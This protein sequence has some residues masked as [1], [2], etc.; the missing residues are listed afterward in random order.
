MLNR[1]QKLMIRDLE[2]TVIP[3]N[4]RQLSEKYGV[5]L[6]T[7]RNDINSIAECLKGKDADFI[8]IPGQ[9][10]RII[11]DGNIS[12]GLDQ[13]LRN[14][15]FP[16]LDGRQRSI[17]LLFN[18]LF[19]KGPLS[20]ADLCTLFDVSKGTVISAIKQSN[21]MNRDLRMRIVRHQNKG[22]CLEASLKNIVNGCGILMRQEGEELIYGTLICDE[23]DFITEDDMEKL[24][25]TLQYISNDLSLYITHH[26]F[27]SFM[28][29]CMVCHSSGST[30]SH[31][32]GET[33]KNDR[34]YQLASYLEDAFSIRLDRNGIGILRHLLSN[35]T[36]YSAHTSGGDHDSLLQEA[37][38]DMIGFVNGSGM[39]QI[40]DIETLRADLLIHLKSTMEAID[41]GLSRDNPLLDEIRS[42]YPNE[43]NLIKSAAQR[44]SGIYPVRLDDDEVG[45]LTLYFLR[46]FDKSEKIQETR[47][48]VV[49]NTGRS[50]SKLLATRLI[51]NIPDI[52]IVSMS[53]IYNIDNSPG[54]LDNVDFV[55]ST[56]P[57]TSISKPY[58]VISPLL[59]KNEIVK[60]KE[61]IWLA[62]SEI[63]LGGS[64]DSVTE[65][66]LEE[67]SKT[68]GNPALNSE[69]YDA[70]NIIPFNAVTLLGEVSMN[71]FYL[72]SDLYPK[73]IPVSAFGNVS[74]IYAHVLMSVPRWQ[75]NEF[76]EPHDDEP[77][78][79][80][81]RKQ[82][83]AIRKYLQ[84][85][86]E[87]L[88]IM[89]PDSEIIAI[90]RYYVY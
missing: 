57:I 24:D 12:A 88:G 34:L 15:E 67:H 78:I 53:S 32:H 80:Q 46:S 16:Y 10:M 60:V 43:F 56:I 55:I 37:V 72:I 77:L 83:E 41:S 39:Y 11:S 70:R 7:V 84:Q 59:Q 71:L 79:R 30:R 52:H 86:S 19:A 50:A 13:V 47:V 75:R 63:Q 22:Y 62:N 87:R 65:S 48:M 44:F 4:A 82:Y 14:R 33:D 36:D 66:I 35:S 42:S 64:V 51:N 23:N 6:R 8:R 31:V 26:L 76:I 28:L 49:C 61:A 9:G 69:Y 54:I 27:L 38:D 85:E 29:Y 5:S 45:Y 2:K 3:V 25:R 74:G 81:H 20:T 18:F 40:D 58:V 90:L 68:P 17:L 73:G 1:R 21:R 89:I